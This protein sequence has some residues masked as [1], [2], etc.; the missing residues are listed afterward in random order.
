MTPRLPSGDAQV[1]FLLQIQRLLE[2]SLFVA[3][4]KLDSM[5]RPAPVRRVP[6]PS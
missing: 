4:Y 3:S 2:E 6:D 5:E 1:A